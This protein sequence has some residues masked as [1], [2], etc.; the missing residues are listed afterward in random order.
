MQ[1]YDYSS[2]LMHKIF[3]SYACY[4]TLSTYLSFYA[5]LSYN[6]EMRYFRDNYA[7]LNNIF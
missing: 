1:L 2:K 4:H 7:E 3:H 5:I 6:L